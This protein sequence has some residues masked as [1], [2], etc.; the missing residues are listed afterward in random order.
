MADSFE[1]K[2]PT[3]VMFFDTGEHEMIGYQLDI[4]KVEK[5]NLQSE[6]QLNVC[7]TNPETLTIKLYNQS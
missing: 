1:D 7:Y 6:S 4:G 2:I 3:P 5:I